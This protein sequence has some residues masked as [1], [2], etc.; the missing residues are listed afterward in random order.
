[1]AMCGTPDHNGSH[2]TVTRI[3]PPL[4]LTPAGT[5]AQLS[6]TV[7]HYTTIWSQTV[8]SYH[9]HCFL[10][11]SA[12]AIASCQPCPALH[13]EPG[14][15]APPAVWPTPVPAAAASPAPPMHPAA[16]DFH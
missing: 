9:H 16:V 10:Q 2:Q 12:V 1:M 8:T 11:L 3:L 6:T 4:V 5:K 14:P 15:A 13:H 7:L